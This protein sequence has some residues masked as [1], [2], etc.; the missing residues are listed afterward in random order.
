M[1]NI[2][3]FLILSLAFA[4]FADGNGK[5]NAEWMSIDDALKKNERYKKDK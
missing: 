5:E 4:V 1:R 3:T 2:V